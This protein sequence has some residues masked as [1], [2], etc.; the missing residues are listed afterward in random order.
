MEINTDVCGCGIEIR[1]RNARDRAPCREIRDTFRDVGPVG[2][3]SCVPHLTIVGACPNKSLLNFGRRNC[4]DDF[5]VE[6]PKIIPDDSPRRYDAGWILG[7]EIRADY[8]PTLA[9]VRSFE[10]YLAAI[11][12]SVVV[13]GIDRERSRPVAAILDLIGRR[14]ESV[15]PRTYRARMLGTCIPARDFIPVTSSP[16]DI[17]IG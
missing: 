1:R 6:L 7:R 14:I 2:S 17:W 10:N 16:N 15:H 13:E 12:D 9:A 3:V 4:E 11:V 8:R 5:S